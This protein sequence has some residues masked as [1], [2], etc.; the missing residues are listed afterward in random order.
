M[1]LHTGREAAAVVTAVL[2]IGE[3]TGV[4]VTADDPA[5]AVLLQGEDI[6]LSLTG[7]DHRLFAR[8]RFEV[9]EQ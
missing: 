4:P 1:A 6:F 5:F 9:K 7:D 8:L 3:E 2:H